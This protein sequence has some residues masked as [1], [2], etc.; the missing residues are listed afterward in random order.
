MIRTIIIL[1][2]VLLCTSLS[3]AQK[4]KEIKVSFLKGKEQ[5]ENVQYYIIEGNDAY[6]LEKKNDKIILKSKYL[7]EDKKELKLLA[8]SGNK[9][10]EFFIKPEEIYYLKII[11]MPFSF[12]YLLKKMYVINQ[13][14]DYEE[15]VRQS[16]KKYSYK[17]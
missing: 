4:D 14:F 1:I 13:G 11:K 2:T 16:K 8:K 10:V 3:F 12:K 17:K 7:K 15:I 9:K 6:L 5:I